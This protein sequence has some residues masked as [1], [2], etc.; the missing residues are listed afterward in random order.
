MT[1]TVVT[2]SITTAAWSTELPEDVVRIGISRGPPR[3]HPKGYRMYRA[4]APGPWFASAA[5]ETYVQRYNDEILAGLNARDVVGD[6]LRISRGQPLAL[7]CFE[8]PFT[9]DG[10]CHRALAARWIMQETGIKVFEHGFENAGC[11]NRHPMLPA[12]LR[13]LSS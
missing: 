2:S 4:L 8:R 7:L 3:G 12:S 6:L 1:G 11:G 9:D 5:A 10:W 13:M